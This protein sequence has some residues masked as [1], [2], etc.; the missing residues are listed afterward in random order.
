MLSEKK[1]F[2]PVDTWKTARHRGMKIGRI[3]KVQRQNKSSICTTEENIVNP[4]EELEPLPSPMI[5]WYKTKRL[6]DITKKVSCFCLDTCTWH[7]SRQKLS[8]DGLNIYFQVGWILQQ[9]SMKIMEFKDKQGREYN[10][11]KD[12]TETHVDPMF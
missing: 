6:K 8:F 4:M 2:A 5:P 3:G 11:Y 9:I 12:V 10:I 1:Y 7:P